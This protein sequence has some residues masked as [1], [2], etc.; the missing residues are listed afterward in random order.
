MFQCFKHSNRFKQPVD[1]AANGYTLVKQEWL[2]GGIWH[3]WKV[4]NDTNTIGYLSKIGVDPTTNR[5]C[6]F[7]VSTD[8]DKFPTN[9]KLKLR[10]FIMGIWKIKHEQQPGDLHSII[11]QNV[12][13]GD[14]Q[15][16]CDEVWSVMMKPIKTEPLC[17]KANG[18]TPEEK[19]AFGLLKNI[20]F[21]RGVQ[22]MLDE[23]EDLNGKIIKEYVLVKP[24][25]SQSLQI[26]LVIG[27]AR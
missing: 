21:C 25:P 6:V 15:A 22:H 5:I 17:I 4:N 9:K 26:E 2:E 12:V 10:D 11:F 27:S 23:Y 19:K 14:V 1:P 24:P 13:G 3:I 18:A 7:E 16:V 8:T 20:F